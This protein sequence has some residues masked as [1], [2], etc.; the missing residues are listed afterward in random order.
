MWQ[1]AASMGGPTISPQLRRRWASIIQGRRNELGWTQED[2]ARKAELTLS[3]IQ[4]IEN[5][6]SG[7]QHVIDKLLTLL[8]AETR[9]NGK[10][11]R[12]A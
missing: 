10:G 5:A 3:Y 9:P 2:L 7:S 4:K 11:R 6:V 8:A 1:N 12:S